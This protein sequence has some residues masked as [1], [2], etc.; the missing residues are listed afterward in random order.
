MKN[1]FFHKENKISNGKGFLPS[2]RK[3]KGKSEVFLSK[4]QKGEMKR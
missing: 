2:K 4:A 1:E 3:I